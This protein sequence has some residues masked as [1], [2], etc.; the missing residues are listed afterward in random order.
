M[1][2]SNLLHANKKVSS[3][4]AAPRK[5]VLHITRLLFFCSANHVGKYTHEYPILH[6]V[7]SLI[8]H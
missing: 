7:T 8:L 3:L 5:D 4:V 2:S 1:N 6:L